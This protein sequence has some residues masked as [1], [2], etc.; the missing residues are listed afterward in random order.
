MRNVAREYGDRIFCHKKG[1]LGWLIFLSL[2]TDNKRR[3]IEFVTKYIF[4]KKIS[5][6]SDE[7]LSS[8]PISPNKLG[9]RLKVEHEKEIYGDEKWH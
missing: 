5:I 7:K 8:S 3:N 1:A 2:N 9:A 4:K 6:I